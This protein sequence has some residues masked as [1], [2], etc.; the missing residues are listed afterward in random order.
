MKPGRCLYDNDNTRMDSETDVK[1]LLFILDGREP[2]YFV[3]LLE[4]DNY[5]AVIKTQFA[6]EDIHVGQSI[7]ARTAW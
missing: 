1:R 3:T 6:H 4:E 5:S 7:T 2:M